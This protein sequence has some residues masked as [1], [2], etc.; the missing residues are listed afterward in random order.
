MVVQ[1]S[2][3]H[4]KNLNRMKKDFI[5]SVSDGYLDHIENIAEELQ[6]LGCEIKQVMKITGVITGRIEQ[7]RNLDE[8][9]I[10]GIDSVEKQRTVRKRKP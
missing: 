1:D 8:L 2:Y 9:H 7:T 10:K 4:L 6:R 3:R 5:A